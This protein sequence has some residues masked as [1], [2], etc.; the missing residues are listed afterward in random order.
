MTSSRLTAIGPWPSV[1]GPT[2]LEACRVPFDTGYFEKI[3]GL[4]AFQIAHSYWPAANK[5][6]DPAD[7][8]LGPKFPSDFAWDERMTNDVMA[9]PVDITHSA[10]GGAIGTQKLVS[11]CRFIIIRSC[12]ATPHTLP[13][14]MLY[15]FR[16]QLF[17]YATLVFRFLYLVGFLMNVM[18]TPV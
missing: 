12:F 10:F 6:K 3:L 1:I 5:D 18:M 14:D 8:F 2:R 17:Y 16:L 15:F 13:F 11:K 4:F 7:L 9:P